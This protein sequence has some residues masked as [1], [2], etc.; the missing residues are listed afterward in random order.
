[1]ESVGYFHMQ[2]NNVHE[3]KLVTKKW[4]KTRPLYVL[5]TKITQNPEKVVFW[6]YCKLQVLHLVIVSTRSYV[7]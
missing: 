5:G 1:M 3:Y 2:L 7:R 4:N 6:G